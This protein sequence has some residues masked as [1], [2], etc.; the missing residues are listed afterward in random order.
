MRRYAVLPQIAGVWFL[1][2]G[3]LARLPVAMVPIGLMLV[4][5]ST[6]GSVARGGLAT[7][8][9]A[10]GT[11]VLAPLQGRLAERIGQ[12]PV[13]LV[14]TAVSSLGLVLVTVAAVSGW[15]LPVLLSVCAV[16]GGTAPQVSPMARVRWLE[17]TRARPAPMSAAMSWE[18]M[19]DELTFVLGPALV[20]G[21]TAAFPHAPL[22]VAAG[23]AAVF[24]LAFALH[25]TAIGPV[26]HDP[27]GPAPSSM[28][29]VLRAV[30]A[31]LAGM[32]SLGA[33]FGSSQAAVTG[34]ATAFGSPGDAGLLYAVMGL[35]SAVTAL[36]VV[37]L[38]DRISDRTRWW[39][40]G[41]GLSLVMTSG[42]TVTTALPT[43]LVLLL[44][45]VFIG[46]AIVTL[47]SLCS[48]LAPQGTA[49]TAM[50]FL[51]SA[52]VVGVA[53]GSAVAGYVAQE[54]NQ[55]GLAA[56]LAFA[57]PAVAAALLTASAALHR[58]RGSAS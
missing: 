41:A 37:A 30:A 18:S 7:S 27:T 9:G 35:G 4:V 10:L 15:S 46:P 26:H 25:P 6:T 38:P 31:P 21:I 19:V 34:V 54:V 2:A 32:L 42:L 14:A 20:G 24:G 16:A 28:A 52:N 49:G 55:A 44:A 36:A 12:R 53:L 48:R 33:V 1:V 50:T 43:A 23:I 22:L 58:S 8:A 29:G 47:F 3:A 13:L 17:L 40:S 56:G 5:T 45:G 11:A 51:I 57:V 39:V